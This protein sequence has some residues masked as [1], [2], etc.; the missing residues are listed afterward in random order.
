MTANVLPNWPAMMRR[1]LAARYC[2]LSVA[3]FER[4]VADGRL[5]MPVRLGNNEHWSRARLDEALER[6][7]SG[8]PDWFSG[9]PLYDAA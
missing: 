1:P 4:E 8:E 5:P 9:S 7:A 2:D 3:E 6:L